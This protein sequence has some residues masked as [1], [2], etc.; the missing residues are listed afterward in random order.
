MVWE[1][2]DAFDSSNCQTITSP[3]IDLL[4]WTLVR[5]PEYARFV[6]IVS[7]QAIGY[8]A[9]QV[10]WFKPELPPSLEPLDEL[11]EHVARTFDVLPSVDWA[12]AA[13]ENSLG[14]VVALFLL[15][16]QN[17]TA[18]TLGIELTRGNKFLSA[19]LRHKA[20]H[21]VCSEISGFKKLKYV[22]IGL[23]ILEELGPKPILKDIVACNLDPLAYLPFFS[24]PALETAVM[25]LPDMDVTSNSVWST[26]APHSSSLRSLRLQESQLSPASL[27][28]LLSPTMPILDLSV[29]YLWNYDYDL[30]LIALRRSLETVKN[31]LTHLT[32][33]CQTW[34]RRDTRPGL[35]D[36][37]GR[38]N[39][40]IL[41]ACSLRNFHALVSVQ[42][43]PTILL[44]RFRR[45]AVAPALADVLPA[46]L[47]NL[48]FR[49][50]FGP[51][52]SFYR[53]SEWPARE[54]LRHST[55]F[56]QGR[57]WTQS[58]ARLR[59]YDLAR[60]APWFS[61]D[62]R[63]TMRLLC[64]ENGLIC[65]CSAEDIDFEAPDE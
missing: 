4:L 61:K 8:H 27:G 3:R 62:Q 6:S 34:S 12:S 38:D 7:L 9:G 24:C 49:R 1:G 63:E 55:E 59:R 57:R 14:A 18:L 44:G 65:Q 39:N 30:D 53:S 35:V 11:F 47:V 16:C 13:N 23:K 52:S 17:I 48:C 54:F 2:N 19:I 64:S 58:H 40:H 56:I 50:D 43:S 32:F 45:T 33:S 60:S 28:L 31:T 15:V 41:G 26:H 10:S 20:F 21:P 37:Y 51:A 42:I 25:K 22:R 36:T 46:N 29:D 5:H